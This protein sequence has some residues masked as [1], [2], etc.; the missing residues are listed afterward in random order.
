MKKFCLVLLIVNALSFSNAVAD[1]SLNGEWICDDIVF[2]DGSKEDTTLLSIRG[3]KLIQ[4]NE[5]NKD[6]LK[7]L[8]SDTLEPASPFKIYTN[9]DRQLLILIK[10]N[11][12]NLKY[13]YVY[14]ASEI[15]VV[16][17][18]SCKKLSN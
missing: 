3:S 18:G 16:S 5:L 9:G 1:N 6:N 2:T 15:N 7:K 8:I 17:T 12:R 10:H 11:S 4:R 14:G 13:T